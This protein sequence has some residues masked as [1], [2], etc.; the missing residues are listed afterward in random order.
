M[1]E[2]ILIHNYGIANM[3]LKK[4]LQILVIGVLIC[5]SFALYF[6]YIVDP[7]GSSYFVA[8]EVTDF[9]E[10]DMI[11]PL[12]NQDFKDYPVL[13]DIIKNK[14]RALLSSSK[15][16]ELIPVYGRRSIYSS[17][18]VP[19]EDAK[20]ISQKYFYSTNNSHKIIL[21]YNSTFYQIVKVTQ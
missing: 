8:M 20:I 5:A 14:K 21:E 10:D 16:V 17:I 19:P 13:E 15:I 6:T 12:T 4:I 11:Y 1:Y 7:E 2:D 18:I 3:N 9:R